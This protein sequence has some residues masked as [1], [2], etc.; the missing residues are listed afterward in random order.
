MTA[1]A[2]PGVVIRRATPADADAILAAHRDSIESL[3]PASYSREAVD[4][5]GH[6]LT[7]ELYINAMNGGEVFFIALGN[8]DGRQEVLG[9]AT[10][11]V[12]DAVRH[13]TAVYVRGS[14]A[15]RGLGSALFRHAEEDVIASG[16]ES[17]EISAS[18]GAVPFYLANGFSETGRGHIRLRSGTSMACVFMTKALP[19]TSGV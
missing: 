6:G 7:P 8:V 14:A 11:R 12:D 17:I 16:A 3:G 9:F 18:L 4:A 1:P 2:M 10:H 13:A 5:W 19:T 15:R